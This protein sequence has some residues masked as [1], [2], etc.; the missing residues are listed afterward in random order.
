MS[1]RAPEFIAKTIYG[2]PV[3]LTTTTF[4]CVVVSYPSK[5]RAYKTSSFKLVEVLSVS[6]PLLS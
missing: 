4:S 3:N 6:L 2:E 1:Y 5:F